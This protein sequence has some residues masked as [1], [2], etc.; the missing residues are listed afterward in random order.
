MPTTPRLLLTLPPTL[1]RHR[2]WYGTKIRRRY[3]VRHRRYMY[4]HG[5]SPSA[6]TFI[7]IFQS[8]ITTSSTP[9]FELTEHEIFEIP[10]ES[11]SPSSVPS[12]K[13]NYQVHN[14]SKFGILEALTGGSGDFKTRPSSETGAVFN[15]KASTSASLAS[16]T[17]SSP[18]SSSSSRIMI[19]SL[20]KRPTNV[21]DKMGFYHQSAPVNVPILPAAMQRRRNEFFNVVDEV[22]EEG[23]GEVVPPH[24]MVAA[25]HSPILACSVLEG[26]GRT[27]KGRDLRQVR[28]AVWR[29]TGFTD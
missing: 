15:H 18:S 8:P 7:G 27:L 29:K 12:P 6:D 4:H 16:S 22:E 1:H 11:S 26:A 14:H 9:S 2:Y 17:S 20:P 19:P 5:R 23:K 10:S 24:E 3:P 21:A 28:S 25:T 13:S